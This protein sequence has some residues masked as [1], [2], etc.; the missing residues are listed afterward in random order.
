MSSQAR[1][2]VTVEKR[3][4]VQDDHR[5]PT[6]QRSIV[7]RQAAAE[8]LPVRLI[9]RR[10]PSRLV[11]EVFRLP[12]IRDLEPPLHKKLLA[13]RSRR[14]LEILKP[15]RHQRHRLPEHRKLR[16]L[17]LP[18]SS[19]RSTSGRRRIRFVRLVALTL[20]LRVSML[21]KLPRTLRFGSTPRR[22]RLEGSSVGRRRGW[23]LLRPC[24]E[25]ISSWQVTSARMLTSSLRS[26]ETLLVASPAHSLH[27]R[28]ARSRLYGQRSS[29]RE[30]R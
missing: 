7:R 10:A 18:R 8:H 14:S 27:A 9:L 12:A 4:T 5:A 2:V 11:G 3:P 17:R 25:L 22:T 26:G 30:D 20:L 19:R 16:L 29:T 1:V 13:Q 24:L 23:A 28:E 15:Q 21:C 6:R